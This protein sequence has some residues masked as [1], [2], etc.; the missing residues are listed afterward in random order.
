M[1]FCERG[2]LSKVI[3]EAIKSKTPIPESDVLRYLGQVLIA[4]EAIHSQKI[5]HRDIKPQNIFLTL[6]GDVKLGDFGVSIALKDTMDLAKT[7][8]GTPYFLCPEIIRH[9]KY[10]QKADIWMIGCTFYEICALRKPFNG[11]NIISLVTSICN[12]DP[13]PLSN[14][15]SDELQDLIL[16]MI[17]KNPDLR[18]NVQDLLETEIL[19]RTLNKLICKR[20]SVDTFVTDENESYHQMDSIE[21]NLMEAI[22]LEQSSVNLTS[23]K[24]FS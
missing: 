3:E 17:N 1:E 14:I 15:Y 6:E 7:A 9:E 12:D 22:K 5:L 2:D 18:P 19:Q 10:N 23:P 20:E 21:R 24:V 4:I 16:S 8:L 11:G 13:L